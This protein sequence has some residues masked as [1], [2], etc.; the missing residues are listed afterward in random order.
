MTPTTW[1]PDDLVVED[2]SGSDVYG[3]PVVAFRVR[4]PREPQKWIWGITKERAIEKAKTLAT[5]RRVSVWFEPLAAGGAR[6]LLG[7]YR[8]T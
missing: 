4:D 6:Q 1:D 8:K 2:C 5:E 7:S 3:D